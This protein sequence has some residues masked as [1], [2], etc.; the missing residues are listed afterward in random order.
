MN[1]RT[2]R[3]IQ[4]NTH[5]RLVAEGQGRRDIVATLDR[6]YTQAVTD[7]NFD[8]LVVQYK[9][10]AAALSGSRSFNSRTVRSLLEYRARQDDEPDDDYEQEGEEERAECRCIQRQ[11]QAFTTRA[12][13][14]SRCDECRDGHHSACEF[15]CGAPDSEDWLAEHEDEEEPAAVDARNMAILNELR[16]KIETE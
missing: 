11:W 14:V 10:V 4:A 12:L 1:A 5:M 3:F 2:Q 7:A 9:Q 8:S 16:R 15:E 13:H 6:L